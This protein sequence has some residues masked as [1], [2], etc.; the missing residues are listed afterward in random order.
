MFEITA[1]VT[2]M[3]GDVMHA[4]ILHGDFFSVENKIHKL[5]KDHTILGVSIKEINVLLPESE[6]E[7]SDTF[8][9]L[10]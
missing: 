9:Y 4:E 7:Y 8:S 3:T 1:I 6:E 5:E 10:R 2:L